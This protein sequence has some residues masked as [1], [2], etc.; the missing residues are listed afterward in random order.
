MNLFKASPFLPSPPLS[1]PPLPP[2]DVEVPL[3]ATAP[4]AASGKPVQAASQSV[5]IFHRIHSTNSVHFLI[6]SVWVHSVPLRRSQCSMLESVFPLIVYMFNVFCL[7]LQ[8]SQK[9]QNKPVNK[10][11]AHFSCFSGWSSSWCS[12]LQ[13]SWQWQW[14]FGWN[15]KGVQCWNSSRYSVFNGY[16]LV[17]SWRFS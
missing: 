13:C 3:V 14:N 10:N 11:F 12:W 2:Q 4:I 17:E 8:N 15:L 1:P 7:G 5:E 16:V 6:V 9:K